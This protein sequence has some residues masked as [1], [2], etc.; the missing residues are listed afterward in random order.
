MNFNNY[1][2]RSRGFVQ[3]AQT[4]AV[5]SGHQQLTPEHLL[6]VLIDDEEGISARLIRAAGGN[7]SVVLNCIEAA[8]EKL[9]SVKGSGA[10]QVYPASELVHFL[11]QA[12]ELAEAAGDNFV[13][14]ERMLIA[15]ALLQGTAAASALADAGGEPAKFEWRDQRASSRA[16]G[17][18]CHR[19][20][21]IRGSQK[22][23]PRS[24][25]GGSRGQ[26]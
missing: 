17:R 22:V 21:P 14:A 26:D 3:S 16:H 1:T 24:D 23:H 7:V 25:I 20:K 6:K 9:P 13:T 2:E 10:G 4:L 5:R 19:R 12:E 15:L 11:K 8:L 18:H